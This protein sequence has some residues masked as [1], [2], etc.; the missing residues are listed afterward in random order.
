MTFWRP[1]KNATF[2]IVILRSNNFKN[3]F[4]FEFTNRKI[5]VCC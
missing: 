4:D 2:L 3:E 5:S 1:R